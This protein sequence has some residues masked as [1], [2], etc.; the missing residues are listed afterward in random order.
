MRVVSIRSK[1]FLGEYGLRG[2]GFIPEWIVFTIGIQLTI[3][4]PTAL[5]CAATGRL[6]PAL[7]MV[8][9]WAFGS[10]LG[11][12]MFTMS[13]PK[14]LSVVPATLVPDAEGK[15]IAIRTRKAA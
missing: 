1:F 7:L 15:T 11:V 4:T 8:S 6:L 13:S 12:V 3:V 10:I 9:D 14:I 2:N 5:F